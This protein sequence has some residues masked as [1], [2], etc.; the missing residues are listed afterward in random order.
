MHCRV[1]V[2][3]IGLPLALA[4]VASEAGWAQTALPEIVVTAPSPIAR[5]ASA[6]T[7]PADQPAAPEVPLQGTLPIVTDQFA[8]VTV[9]PSDELQ[10]TP[11]SSLGDVLQSKPGITGSSFAPGSASRPI[12]RGLDNYRV[13]I[14]E[15]GL[16]VN[17]V[18]DLSED[19]AVPIDPLAARQ[20]EVIRGPA[21]LR[22]GSQAIGGVVNVDNNRIPTAIPP[23]G[24]AGELNGAVTTVDG[25]VEGSVLLDAGGGNFAVHADAYGRRAENYRIPGYPY[26]F[27]PAPAPRVNGHQPNS[28]FR[29]NGQSVG[30]SYL[31]DGGFF[32]VAVSRFES[33][34]RIPGIEA[35][36]TKTRIDMHQTKITSKGEVRPQS[37]AIEA[38]RFWLGASDYK[39]DELAN[40]GGFDGVHQTFRNRA[41]EGRVEV[42]LAPVNLPFAALTSAFG[43]Q[44]SHQDL[45]APGGEGGLFDPNESTSAA[46]YLFNELRFSDTL[47][48]QVAGRIELANVNGSSPSF[49]ANFLPIGIDPPALSRNRDFVPA[50]VA[51]GLLKDLPWGIVGSVNAQYVERAPRAPELFSRGVHEATGTFEIGN[52]NLGI[53]S[54]QTVEVGLR[55]AH[56]RL[57]FEATAYYTR[58]NGFI[59]KRF[60]GNT[61]DEDFASCIAGPGGEL[62]QVAYTQR[63]AT[64]GGGEVQAQFDVA[65]LSGGMFGVDGQYD[66]VHA[67]FADGTYVPRIPP[68]RIGGGVYWR[69]SEWF[70]R[71]GLLHAFAQ[72]DTATRE[73][74]TAG[75]NLLK[76]EISHTRKLDPSTFG[77]RELTIGV[78]GN[79]L[80]N[81]DIRNAVSFKKD[82]VLL[83][84]LNVRFFASVRF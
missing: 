53:E 49:P 1:V 77:A 44:A 74:P 72:N 26:L 21:T 51:V 14:Q 4:V 83:P 57:R 52:P 71:V 50:S 76:A 66:I 36:E 68:Q 63:D 38:V 10:R 20:I 61:C 2:R 22:W 79:N 12:V 54:A 33:F 31:F 48:L 16:A 5:P 34:Y 65:P 7:P 11:G 56:G 70:V 67:T 43:V 47:R 46:A 39:H 59:F 64:F 19:H 82:E 3:R 25:G 84:G 23:R 58:F 27:P 13:R 45:S 29:S 28:S 80:L 35:T 40:E 73:T 17:D 60:T 18:S 9:I 42:Q 69:S 41:Q 6:A 32:G 78:V 81:E 62:T 15:N 30:G 75:Y 8:T 24:F 55:R 37:A